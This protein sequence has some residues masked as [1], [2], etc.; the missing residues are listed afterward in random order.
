[1]CRSAG[2]SRPDVLGRGLPAGG[3]DGSA[4]TREV[5]LARLFT[6]SRLDA[7]GKPVMDPGSSSYVATFDGK[8]ALSEL[9]EAEYLRR[10]GNHFLQV[11]GDGLQGASDNARHP[12]RGHLPRPRAPA[13][14]GRPPG[15]HHPR[16]RC[17]AQRREEL[18]AG[19]ADAII[20]AARSYPLAGIKAEELD[21]KLGYFERNGHRM[22]YARYRHLGMFTGSGAIE[23]GIKAIVVQRAKQAGMHWTTGGAASIIALRTQHA[24]NRC[25]ELWP[26]P[27]P[28]KTGCTPPSDIQQDSDTRARAATKIISNKAGVHPG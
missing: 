13:R 27:P 2:C 11:V 20:A 21:K 7:D 25:D 1:V 26:A 4:G 9:V 8:H 19:K 24:S 17:L 16:P 12:H 6:V 3:E 5:K 15:L 23:G 18:D 14:P 10:G 22:R 28:R